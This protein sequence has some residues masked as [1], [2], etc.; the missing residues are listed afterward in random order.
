MSLFLTLNIFQIFS[1]VSIIDFGQV[2]VNYDCS[3]IIYKT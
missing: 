1:G 3:T 2:Y